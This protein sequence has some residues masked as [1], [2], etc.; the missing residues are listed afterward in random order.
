VTKELIKEAVN[1]QPFRP[2]TVCMADGARYYVPERD[3][4]TITPGGRTLIIMAAPE[5]VKLL[6]VLLVTEIEREE[7][8]K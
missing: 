1:A 2:F 3:F 5:K 6:D 4:V 7:P 8:V